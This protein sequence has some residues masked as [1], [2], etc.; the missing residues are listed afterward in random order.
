MRPLVSRARALGA[1]TV[2]LRELRSPNI[3]RHNSL[4]N[5]L[6]PTIVPMDISAWLFEHPDSTIKIDLAVQTLTIEDG[7][8]V[9]FPGDAF[10][11]HCLLEGVD[12]LGYILKQGARDSGVRGRPSGL[13]ER[14]WRSNGAA[15]GRRIGY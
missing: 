9:T 12:E 11:K 2:R 6:V 7:R 15:D 1:N 8:S 10:A 13:A 5:G 4:K 3:L 14:R